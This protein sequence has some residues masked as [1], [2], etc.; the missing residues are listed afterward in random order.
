MDADDV[1][2]AD[3]ADAADYDD[4]AGDGDD[5]FPF[6]SR[7]ELRPLREATSMATVFL[8]TLWWLGAVTPSLARGGGAGRARPRLRRGCIGLGGVNASH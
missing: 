3:D 6:A 7:H 4:G 8:A 5:G 2:D 1:E